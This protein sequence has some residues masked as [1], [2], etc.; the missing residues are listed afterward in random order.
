LII[1]VSFLYVCFACARL[2]SG[3]IDVVAMLR[4]RTQL[5][6]FR[7]LNRNA[8]IPGAHAPAAAAAAAV[9]DLVGDVPVDEFERRQ[10]AAEAASQHALDGRAE[11]LQGTA[12]ISCAGHSCFSPTDSMEFDFSF[13]SCTVPSA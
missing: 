1:R 6:A 13:L 7:H 11:E 8:P 4:L 3:Q 5:A 9:D 2:Q 12:L 10:F